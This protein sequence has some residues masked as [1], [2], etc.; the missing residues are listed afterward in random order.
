M[1][2][3]LS[4][5]LI[6]KYTIRINKHFSNCNKLFFTLSIRGLMTCFFPQLLLI[7]CQ[8]ILLHLVYSVL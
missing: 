7:T 5:K 6:N 8:C 4:V 3:N 2:I 1:L